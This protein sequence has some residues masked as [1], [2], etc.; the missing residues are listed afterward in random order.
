MHSRSPGF[1]RAIR[2]GSA[3]ALL[4]LVAALPSF[5]VSGADAPP[6][7]ITEVRSLTPGTLQLTF[8]APPGVEVA[9]LQGDRVELQDREVLRG[10]TD[11]SGQGMFAYSTG[12]PDSAAFFRLQAFPWTTLEFRSP[13]PN[14]PDVALT[15]ETRL[16]FSRPLA[17]GTVLDTNHLAS[18]VAGRRLLSR[19]ELGADRQT[20]TLF[21]LEPLPSASRIEVAWEPAG[22][23]DM[24]GR[25]LDSDDDG[26]PGGTARWGFDTVSIT[27]V[28]GTVV[29][30][31]VFASDPVGDGKGGVT[32][33]P[34]AGVT[35]TVDG[36]EE[37]LRTT[38]GADGSFT[39]AP[40]P[41]GTFFA[42]VDGRTAVGS[43]WPDGAYYPVVGKLWEAVA[44]V[45]N[46]VNGTGEL[47][48]PRIAAGAL[49]P[50]S[51][52]DATEIRFADEVLRENPTLAGVSVRVPANAL[53][54]DSG[55]RGGRVG[56]APVPADRLP[57]PLPPGLELPLV[58]TIQTDGAQNFAVPVPVRFPNLPDPATGVRATAGSK[59]ALWS[60]NH[61]T[62]HWELQGP[63]TVTADGLLVESDPGV[64]VRQPG[65][66][67]VRSGTQTDGG[68]PWFC[69][70]AD[71]NPSGFAEPCKR[72]GSA[73]ACGVIG[74]TWSKW[75]RCG[76]SFLPGTVAKQAAECATS[77]TSGVLD[78]LEGALST[79]DSI[80]AAD[81]DKGT[82]IFRTFTLTAKVITTGTLTLLDCAKDLAASQTVDRF[83]NC[84]SALAAS[85]KSACNSLVTPVGCN[86]SSSMAGACV[87]ADFLD[88]GFTAAGA[89]RSGASFKNAKELGEKVTASFEV[90]GG[91]VDAANELLP[92]D[93]VASDASTRSLALPA[94]RAPAAKRAEMLAL[95]DQFVTVLTE[96]KSLTARQEQLLRT[97]SDLAVR[98]GDM[99]VRMGRLARDFGIPLPGQI[100]Y[101]IEADHRVQRGV[102][103]GE[104]RLILAPGVDYVLHVY[105][106]RQGLY[107]R[108]QGTTAAAGF[109]TRL[110]AVPLAV[111]EGV[112]TDADGL[113]D[114]AEFVVG[115]NPSLADTD[116]DGAPDGAE[117]RAGANPID[118]L[119]VRTGPL[120]SAPTATPATAV[121]VGGGRLVAG[122]GDRGLAVFDLGNP[123]APVRRSTVAVPGAVLDLAVQDRWVAVAGGA[124]G[125]A[126][127]DLANPDVPVIRHRVDVGSDAEAVAFVRGQAVALFASGELL[128]LDPATGL[129][130]DRRLELTSANDM[131]AIGDLVVVLTDTALHTYRVA[132]GRL[133]ALGEVPVVGTPVGGER[134]RALALDQRLAVVA[135]GQ[136]F[137]TVDLQ[138]PGAPRVLATPPARQP[139]LHVAALNGSGLLL[140]VTSTGGA[141]TRL[142]TL[143]DVTDPAVVTRFITT[144]DT[145]GTAHAFALH[146]GLA[147][148]ADGAAGVQVFNYLSPG[149]TNAAPRVQLLVDGSAV[150][151]QELPQGG[152]VELLAPATDD[153]QV[154]EIDFVADDE[155][156][157]RLSSPPFAFRWAPPDTAR[158]GTETRLR[159]RAIDMEGLSAWSEPVVIRWTNPP[160]PP[161]VESI[162]PGTGTRIGGTVTMARVAFSHPMDATT[163]DAS[164]LTLSAAGADGVAGTPDDVALAGLSVTYLE[165]SAT[166]VVEAT[167][168][169]SPGTYAVRVDA[170]I[171]SRSGQT[172]SE[173]LVSTFVVD[174]LDDADRDGLPDTLE[175]M[176]GFE[177]R[178]SDTDRDGIVDGDEDSDGDGVSDAR[179]LAAGTTFLARLESNA[180]SLGTIDRVGRRNAHLLELEAGERVLVS[181]GIVSGNGF[182]YLRIFG[183]GGTNVGAAQ[184]EPATLAEFQATT[185]GAYTIV[186]AEWGADHLVNYRLTALRVTK[187]LGTPSAGDEG[188]LL[189]SNVGVTGALP[190]GDLDGYGIEA[191]VGD[192]LVISVGQTDGTGLPHLWVFGPDGRLMGALAGRFANQVDF[193]AGT[194]GTHVIVVGEWGND[195]AVGYRLNAIRAH[196]VQSAPATGDDGSALTSNVATGG[197]LPVGDVDAFTIEAAVGDRLV[198]SVGKTA[199]TGL[200]HLRVFGPDGRIMG[201]VEGRF[202]DQ[203]DFLAAV[204]GPH[205]IVI[206]EWGND[207]AADYRLSAIRAQGSQG[208]PADG[209]EGAALVSNV[210]VTGRLPVGDVDAF[211]IGAAVG[212]RLVV[213]VGK[214]AGTGLAHLRVFAPDGRLMGAVEGRF[215]TQIDFITDVAGSHVVVVGEWGN[216]HAVDYRLSA[217]R[218]P[219]PQGTPAPG[220]DGGVLTSNVSVTGSLP[221]GDI[222]AFSVEALPNERLIV[223]VGWRAGGGLPYLRVFGPDG[224]HRSSADGRFITQVEFTTDLAGTYHVV[225]AEW[226][227]DHPVDYRLTV[228]RVPTVQSRVPP[229]ADEGSLVSLGTSAIGSLPQGDLDVFSVDVGEGGTLN[230]QVTKT[231][232]AGLPYLRVYD[233]KGVPVGPSPG[234]Y[235]T[236]MNLIAAT[237]ETYT[238]IVG[239]FGNDHPVDYSL[240]LL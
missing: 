226:G 199:G 117:L 55:V 141:A 125:L 179:E 122:L 76:S 128:L 11:V 217:L 45:N 196:G 168:P 219:G 229:P 139:R 99:S 95:M 169:L 109:V 35:V 172:L 51:A 50:V 3:C 170:S 155:R 20:A 142:L 190:Q 183:P 16:Q 75:A 157:S 21:H 73:I 137:T 146:A 131:A 89:L 159:A 130:L 64:G 107:G 71:F 192:R 193:Q 14:E 214:T 188:L 143:Y 27:P 74:D 180:T 34:L 123:L 101:A 152:F 150:A 81:D 85:L 215:D 53:Y 231:A 182:P 110:P 147:Y 138:D 80:A 61:D 160:A 112:D 181:V 206:S 7:R 191:Q 133:I 221:I 54:A 225:V 235:V 111:L 204:E 87:G 135:H 216:D 57:E 105:E 171:R 161:R 163:V 108:T 40:C 232:G 156:I 29:T 212:D 149:A 121:G 59:S 120:A 84:G 17:A 140:G 194:E 1:I 177:A 151:R 205:V 124:G 97:T 68:Q 186:V 234:S 200:P 22:V 19:V 4:C 13:A 211:T 100:H 8:T 48:L 88:R 47:F 26:A 213:S 79:K 166:A 72:S 198:I 218:S 9:L 70:R 86:E 127:V 41:S 240:D 136:G 173:A 197:S 228:A 63:M 175:A 6:V 116:G 164:R 195:H 44:G 24:D 96:L 103:R 176:W 67:G 154:R 90:L 203:V 60:F 5:P 28:F 220:D 62:G 38:T 178:R 18:F 37:T 185:G 227:N 233:S 118:G 119:A 209:D 33:R 46:L 30:G 222:D 104:L 237:D 32:N 187:G 15:R 56:L 94:L 78:L 126:L 134:G 114:E 153:G 39:L 36:A 202:A 93:S 174:T 66:H 148:V 201:A 83:L 58:I 113:P 65:W 102:H 10:R 106:P 236:R 223:S 77:L 184:G 145:P 162:L 208:S 12:L 115:T 52:T 23:R 238:I 189:T 49:V 158:N 2:K 144:F 165:T 224:R 82:D 31:R 25:E 91:L 132:A 207:H 43:A 42:T 230:L 129:L 92:S 69:G 98:C 239:E 210:E 167:S